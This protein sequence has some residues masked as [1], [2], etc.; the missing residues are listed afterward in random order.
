MA[1]HTHTYTYI[2][3]HAHTHIHHNLQMSVVSEALAT[4][5]SGTH[6]FWG[7]KRETR[8]TLGLFMPPLESDT[9]D[10]THVSLARMGH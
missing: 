4:A 7:R 2:Y 5:P 8:V 3:T 6:S 9:G 10:T 1:T